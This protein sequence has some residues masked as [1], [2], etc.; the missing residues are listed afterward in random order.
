MRAV[1]AEAPFVSKRTVP[2]VESAVNLRTA[3]PENVAI[4]TTTSLNTSTSPT[5]PETLSVPEAVYA[6]V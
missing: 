5:T 2:S 3:E 6:G 1:S 4:P